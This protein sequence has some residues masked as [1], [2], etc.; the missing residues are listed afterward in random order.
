MEDLIIYIGNWDGVIDI[1]KRWREGE[2]W[3]RLP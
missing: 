2:S 3:A 1:K